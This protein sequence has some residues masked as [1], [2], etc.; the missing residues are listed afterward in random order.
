MPSQ[1]GNFFMKALINSPLH[2]LL[3]NSFAV[4]TVT[5]RKTGRTITTPI[6]TVSI[7][8]ALTVIS[9]RERT[10]WRNLRDG[11]VAQLRRAGKQLPVRAEVV[12]A[13]ADVTG[14]MEKY[15]LQFPAYAKYFNIHPGPDGKP[16]AYELERL[17]SERVIIRLF[18]A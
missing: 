2:P 7:G 1:L 15:F 14:W 12:E 5:G 3:G 9:M 13:P 10:W 8:D 18:P 17:G 6:N 11:R 4:I 16:A